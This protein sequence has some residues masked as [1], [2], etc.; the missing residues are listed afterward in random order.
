MQVGSKSHTDRHTNLLL[1][2]SSAVFWEMPCGAMT[3]AGIPMYDVSIFVTEGALI[4]DVIP[5]LGTDEQNH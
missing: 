4:K 1:S 5:I 3:P 2:N